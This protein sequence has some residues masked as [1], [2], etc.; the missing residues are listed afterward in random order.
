MAEKLKDGDNFPSLQVSTVNN[1]SISI[2][3]DL[4]SAWT[5]LLFYR[6]WW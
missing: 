3:A 5:V 1:G 6:G 2:P 4:T